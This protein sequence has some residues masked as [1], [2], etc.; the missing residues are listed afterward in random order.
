[1]VKSDNEVSWTVISQRLGI[2]KCEFQSLSSYLD[3]T[4]NPISISRACWSRCWANMLD[5]HDQEP[6]LVLLFAAWHRNHLEGIRQKLPRPGFSLP[7][8][9]NIPPTRISA[10]GMPPETVWCLPTSNAC[11]SQRPLVKLH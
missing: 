3:S 11:R 6:Q 5:L 4:L 7:S 8:Q 10:Y 9:G 1:M 2:L